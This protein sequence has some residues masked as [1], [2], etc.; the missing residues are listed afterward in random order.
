MNTRHAQLK[1]D[2]HQHTMSSAEVMIDMHGIIKKFKNAAGEFTVLKG[3]DL[4]INR[5]EFV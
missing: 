2:P 3:I 5:S 4:T 1:L